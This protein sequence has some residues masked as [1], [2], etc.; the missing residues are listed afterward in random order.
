MSSAVFCAHR[1]KPFPRYYSRLNY[2]AIL[3][4]VDVYR[5]CPCDHYVHFPSLSELLLIAVEE[6]T[7]VLREFHVLRQLVSNHSLSLRAGV[8]IFAAFLSIER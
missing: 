8:A 6:Y 4:P 5:R 2:V 1:L 7:V 3:L